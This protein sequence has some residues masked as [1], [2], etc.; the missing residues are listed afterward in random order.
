MQL[1]ELAVQS[2]SGIN[3]VFFNL[4]QNNYSEEERRIKEL[5][6][7][8]KIS[9]SEYNNQIRILRRKQAEDEK[10]QAVFST[11]LQQGPV[12][13]EGFKKGGFAG[14]AAAFTLFFTMLNAVTSTKVPQFWKGETKKTPPG[15]KWVGEK[16]P[17]LTYDPGGYKVLTAEH[18]K[19]L[20]S[21]GFTDQKILQQYNIPLEMNAPKYSN[22]S[23]TDTPSVQNVTTVQ[24]AEPINYEKLGDVFAQKLAENPQY[25]LSFDENG[26]MLSVKQGNDEIQYKNKKL[27]T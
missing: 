18:S 2:F 3:Q 11:L 23:M 15:F 26:F 5:Y 7:L 12:V 19:K 6:D 8:K 22:Y 17:E 10:A 20:A 14:I 13:L 4:S 21:S 24:Q 16:G 9:E 25:V 27:N 1:R